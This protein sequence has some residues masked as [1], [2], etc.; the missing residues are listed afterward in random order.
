VALPDRRAIKPALMTVLRFASAPFGELMGAG[1][2]V[3]SVTGKVLES[4]IIGFPTSNL[5]VAT[6]RPTLSASADLYPPVVHGLTLRVRGYA[7]PDW[8]PGQFLA[9]TRGRHP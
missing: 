5:D 2:A 7:G 9:E 8:L 6:R 4:A 3:D 1:E